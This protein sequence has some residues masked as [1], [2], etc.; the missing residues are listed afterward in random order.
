MASKWNRSDSNLYKLYIRLS[1]DRKSTNY[2]I[3][4]I[5][6]FTKNIFLESCEKNNH[7]FD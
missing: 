5:T 7:L 2:Y 4:K 1:I 6:L 3:K